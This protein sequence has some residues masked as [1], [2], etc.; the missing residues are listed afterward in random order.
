MAA[1]TGWACYIEATSFYDGPDGPSADAL[2]GG[3][4]YLSGSLQVED[5]TYFG[6]CDIVYQLFQ[7]LKKFGLEGLPHPWLDLFV[8]G[9]AID[10]FATATVAGLQAQIPADKAVPGTIVL[11]FP[12]VADRFR[13]PLLRVPD[14]DDFFLFDIL[15]TTPPDPA[16]V[17]QALQ[18]NRALYDYNVAQGGTSYVISAVE[19][20][21]Q[22]WKNHF[23]SEWPRLVSAKQNY[24]PANVL[25]AG[26]GVFP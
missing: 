22:D 2:L 6:F 18:A 7:T 12:L 21:P 1:P 16:A 8:P 17:R 5:Y 20:S 9:E 11:F 10:S 14:G 25:G 15:L 3:L 26:P 19:L 23:Q 24:D 13:R 4:G